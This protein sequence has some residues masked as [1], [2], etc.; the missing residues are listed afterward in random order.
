VRPL[1][2]VL[3]L[4]IAVSCTQSGGPRSGEPDPNGELVTNMG[5]EPDTIDPHKASFQNEIGAVMMVFEGLMTLDPQTL[6]PVPAAAAKDPEVSADG[7]VWKFTL[8]DGLKYSDGSPLTAK[9]FAYGFSR[10]CDPATAGQYAFVLFVIVGCEDW[11]AMD[12]K[13]ASKAELD[14]ARGRL[15][16]KV[17]SEKEIQFN[18]REPAAYF[19]SIAYMWVGMPARESDVAKAGDRWTEPATYIGNGP[20]KLT[21]WRHNDKMVYERNTHYREPAK[22][23]KWTKV[24]IAEGAVAF[25][26]YRNDELDLTGVAAEQLRTVE[27]DQELKA[28]AVDVG[29]AATF[30]Y[31][32]NVSRAPFNEQPVRLAFAKS[33]DRDAYV[34]DVHKLGVPAGGGFIPPG[35]PGFDPD[36]KIQSF[37]PAAARKLLDQASPAAREAL[38]TLKFAYSSSAAS[39]TRVEWVVGQWKQHLGVELGLDPVDRTAYSSMV[40]NVQTTPQ[41]FLLGWIADFPDPQN[42]HT[43]VWVSKSGISSSRVGYAN[44]EFDRLVRSADRETDPAKREATY[45]QA[46]RI[47]SQDAPAAWLF[48][49]ASKYLKKPWVKGVVNT[50]VDALLGQ[51]RLNQLYVTKKG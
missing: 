13:R 41:L 5:G 26:A 12:A 23:K 8:R 47:L 17:L 19:R 31:G 43:T 35:I 50:P 9:D 2:L 29:G 32:F 10:T 1:A 48:Y 6:R 18:L 30:Y 40:K 4:A 27:N 15:G 44:A 49:D 42:W 34:R 7:L 22:L 39:K 45:K 37:D 3:A 11:N 20:F 24:M 38:R 25:A 16:I 28:Q 36:D 46:G 21:E 33:F 51:F 14:A